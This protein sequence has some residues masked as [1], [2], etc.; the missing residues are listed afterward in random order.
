MKTSNFHSVSIIGASGFVGLRATEILSSMPDWTVRPIVRSASSLAVI[1]RQRLDWRISDLLQAKPLAEAL[2]GSAVCVHAAIGDAS[3]IVRMA[4]ETYRA[5]AL[6][7]VRR[8]VW[9]SSASVHGQNA[10]PGTTDETPLRDDQPLVY[11]N[12]KVRAEWVLDRLARNGKVEVVHLRPS[13]VFGPRSRWITD[14]AAEIRAGHAAWLNGGRGICNTIYIDNL[15]EAI[16]LAAIVPG[17]AGQ[18]FLVGDA[19]TVTWSEFLETIAEHFG[20]GR[21]GFTNLPIPS[22]SAER[23]S[24]LQALTLTP[25]YGRLAGLLP[26]RFKRLAKGILGAWPQPATPPSVWTLRATG[27]SPRLT[28]ELALLQQCTWK[29]PHSRASQLLGYQPPISF[30]EGMARSLAWLDFAEGRFSLNGN[31]QSAL[32][33]TRR[34]F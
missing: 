30:I 22:F 13:V 26:G 11:N 16:R 19:E 21:S 23:E 17:I 24:R 8:L 27:E 5:C 29:L 9:L 32:V 10:A 3:Q 18:A 34:T 1:A 14:A 20:V 4:R 6:A 31:K 28:H 33:P 25:A 12:A 15:V 2:R 7:G